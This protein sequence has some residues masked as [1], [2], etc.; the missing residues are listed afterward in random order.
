MLLIG[1]ALDHFSVKKIMAFLILGTG[2]STVGLAL[3]QGFWI[4]SAMLFA[5]ATV[6]YAFFPAT[7]TAIAKLTE[8]HERSAFTGATMGIATVVGVGLSPVILGAIA[9]AWNFQVGIFFLGLLVS[10][11]FL[12]LR[13]LQDV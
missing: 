11:S 12:F 3:A 4:L 2:L 8:P 5:Q 6:C 9:D 1:F 7:L 10:L 13:R